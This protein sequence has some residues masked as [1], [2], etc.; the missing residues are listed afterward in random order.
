MRDLMKNKLS[1]HS[2]LAE[3]TF[4]LFGDGALTKQLK[5]KIKYT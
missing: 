2:R 3:K 4:A 1:L 5:A